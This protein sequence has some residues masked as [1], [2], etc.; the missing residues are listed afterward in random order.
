LESRRSSRLEVTSSRGRHWIL[1]QPSGCP[2]S[3]VSNMS[4]RLVV[5]P[6][7]VSRDIRRSSSWTFCNQTQKLNP[8]FIA[9]HKDNNDL[10]REIVRI[11]HRRISGLLKNHQRN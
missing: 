9:A 8:P 7:V 5:L 4:N 10:F 3:N 1:S 2:L 11:G 6:A